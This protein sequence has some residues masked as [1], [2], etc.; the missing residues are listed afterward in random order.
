MK[1]ADI[2]EVESE[3]EDEE[4]SGEEESVEEEY[5]EDEVQDLLLF[6]KFVR[7]I[8]HVETGSTFSG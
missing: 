6:R 3:I 4:S 1:K 2:E 5:E 8:S 7:R